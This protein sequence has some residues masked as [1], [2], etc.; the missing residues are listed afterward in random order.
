MAVLIWLI[1]FLRDDE[2]PA[3]RGELADLHDG[4]SWTVVGRKRHESVQSD[5]TNTKEST[6]AGSVCSD[7]PAKA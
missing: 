1:S 4:S 3:S 7:P 6:G 5:A 2:A